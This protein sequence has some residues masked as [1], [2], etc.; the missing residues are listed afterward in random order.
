MGDRAS[1]QFRDSEGRLSAILNSHWGG[2]G[3]VEA[4]QKFLRGYDGDGRWGQLPVPNGVST[5]ESKKEADTLMVEF[6]RSNSDGDRVVC[7]T[8]DVDN[9]DHG[10]FTLNTS[11]GSIWKEKHE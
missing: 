11:D 2:M 5:P 3:F 4:A 1:I 6:I 8:K 9:S 7:S 10:H